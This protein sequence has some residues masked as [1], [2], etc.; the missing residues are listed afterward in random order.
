[1]RYVTRAAVES[2]FASGGSQ[3]GRKHEDYANI[4]LM[5]EGGLI[6][7]IEVNWIPDFTGGRCTG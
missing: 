7:V 2:V 1:M 5:M 3:M 6:G 4:M